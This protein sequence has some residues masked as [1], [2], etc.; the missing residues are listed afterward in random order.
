M[1]PMTA[2]CQRKDEAQVILESKRPGAN[3]WSIRNA[4]F[5]VEAENFLEQINLAIAERNSWIATE[6]NTEYRII[7]DRGRVLNV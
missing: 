6:P 1:L 4:R 3:G 2:A 7:T 5:H